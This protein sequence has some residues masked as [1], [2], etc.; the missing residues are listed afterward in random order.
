M[1]TAGL[2]DLHRPNGQ[3]PVPTQQDTE[4][5]N[6]QRHALD[7]MSWPVIEPFTRITRTLAPTIRHSAGFGVL[8][9][10]AFLANALVWGLGIWAIIELL[11]R[12]LLAV[13]GV[14]PRMT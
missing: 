5:R 2:G 10:L 1:V 9:H 13:F 8:Q 11:S 4:T 3:E 7:I 12:G 14:R 6:F